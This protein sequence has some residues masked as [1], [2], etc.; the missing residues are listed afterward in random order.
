VF[1]FYPIQRTGRI[2]AKKI[3]AY[4]EKQVTLRGRSLTG[5]RR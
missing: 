2:I 3:N 4:Y 1:V 5:E